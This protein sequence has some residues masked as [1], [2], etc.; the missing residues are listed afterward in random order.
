MSDNGARPHEPAFSAGGRHAARADDGEN[1]AARID[2]PLVLASVARDARLDRKF[3]LLT[4]L[5]AA[6]AT[7]GLL[8]GSTA[9]VIGAMLVS[10]LL[11]PIMG[12]GFGLA[13]IDSALIRRALVT[14]GAGMAAAIALSALLILLSPI[15]DVTQELTNRTQPNLFDL[16]V[17][18]V[19][20]IAG[21][22]AI[23]RKLSGIMVGVS[24]ATALVPPLCTVG[25]GLATGRGDYA[26][27]AA[28]LF[29]TNTLAITFAATAIARLNRFGPSLT[30]QHTALQLAGILLV[31]G[32]LSIPLALSLNRLVREAAARTV[33]R[34]ELGKIVAGH[35]RIDALNVQLNSGRVGVDG[36]VLVESY[37]AG[38]AARL[39]QVTAKRLNRPIDVS[40][41][42]IRQEQG[43]S[44]EALRSL[45]DR[46]SRIEARDAVVAGIVSALS[47]GGLL[48][49]SDLSIDPQSQ[50]IAVSRDRA[51]ETP[52][53]TAAIDAA[54][55]ALRDTH[56]D[57][58]IVEYPPQSSGS[59]AR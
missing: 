7:L 5:S 58:R 15:R 23:L 25:F 4:T 28:L 20:G 54:L 12:L 17:A 49:R 24:I 19:G 51:A 14:L 6:I 21:V 29:L 3:L 33:V 42:Q 2:R 18:I 55:A 13:T 41:V 36:V 48:A 59:L 40:L 34:T 8:Q 10:P 27:G 38:L 50:L 11:G 44:G 46:L 56:P 57:W 30:P 35:G 47:D 45:D 26:L 31:L 37:D 52:E 9:V 32:V 43:R 1:G 53:R 39:E 16:G 22:Y